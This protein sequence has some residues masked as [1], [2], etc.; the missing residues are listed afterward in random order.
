MGLDSVELLVRFEK[1]F[2]V[3]VPDAVAETLATP[4]DVADWISQCLAL[5]AERNSLSREGVE[6]HLE[7]LFAGFAPTADTRLADLLPTGEVWLQYAQR[8]ADQVGWQLPEIGWLQPPRARG[9]LNQLFNWTTSVAPPD[10]NPYCFADLIDWTLARN[11]DLLVAKPWHNQYEV[12]QAI[13]GMTSDSSG[14]KVSE[15]KP[16]SHFVYDLGID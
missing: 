10:P 2:E 7:A 11:Y 6:R 14:V 3:D 5:P 8:L 9:W 1:Y 12:L 13:I 16:S 15:I 4:A